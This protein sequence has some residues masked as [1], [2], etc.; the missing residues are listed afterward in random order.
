VG[1]GQMSFLGVGRVIT[2]VVQSAVS[3][4]AVSP[5]Q[6]PTGVG[7]IVVCATAYGRVASAVRRGS[8]LV[9]RR[10]PDAVELV[11]LGRCP[12]GPRLPR[13]L[14]RPGA[15]GWVVKTP[16]VTLTLT[17][18]WR[19]SN[20]LFIRYCSWMDEHVQHHPLQ[21]PGTL[22]MCTLGTH[23]AGGHHRALRN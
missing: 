4:R 16:T 9:Q 6:R 21:L 3:E 23:C 20:V 13:H 8:L 19:L 1:S 5:G 7:S 15:H 12:R 22:T 18:M 11:P 2:C 10:R 17:I 14:W